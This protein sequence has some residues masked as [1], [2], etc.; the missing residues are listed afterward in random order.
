ME[1]AQQGPTPGANRLAGF[2]SARLSRASRFYGLRAGG[3]LLYDIRPE[4]PAS[5]GLDT[6]LQP[7]VADAVAVV[8]AHALGLVAHNRINGYLVARLAR[9]RFNDVPQAVKA[10][11]LAID[12]ELDEQ[13]LELS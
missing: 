7:V 4:Q 13:L 9:D 3:P 12:A 2:A 11:T 5:Y 10:A 6:F 1:T 8:S